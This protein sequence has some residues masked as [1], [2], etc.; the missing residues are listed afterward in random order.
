MFVP[1][2]SDIACIC[3]LNLII[4]Y[5]LCQNSA[6]NLSEPNLT[7]TVTPPLAI[8]LNS[9]TYAARDKNSVT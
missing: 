8:R 7:I 4:F 6:L 2:I 3:F 9:P 5:L 1:Y